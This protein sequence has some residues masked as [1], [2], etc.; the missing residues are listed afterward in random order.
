MYENAE[1][2]EY[3]VADVDRNGLNDL[4]VQ[5]PNI[6]TVLLD[7]EGAPPSRDGIF[8]IIV[9]VDVWEHLSFDAALNYTV[10]A[11]ERLAPEGLL[12]LQVPN[13]GCPVTP[14]TFFGDLTHRLMFNEKSIRQLLRAASVPDYQVSVLPRRTPGWLGSIRDALGVMFGWVFRLAFVFF[15][16]P[17]LKIFSADLIALVH[18][19]NG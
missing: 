2:A 5:F 11:Y 1:V 10:W 12:V 3:S 13:W 4:S 8:D 9:A 18:K 15:G 19:K 17:R 16:S 6:T 14:L 7:S